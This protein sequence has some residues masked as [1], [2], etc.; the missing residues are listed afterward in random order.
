MRA[1]DRLNLTD[2]IGRELQS[3]YGYNE[4]DEFLGAFGI[5]PP[6]GITF[7]SKWV[8]SKAALAKVPES[9][10]LK[11]ASELELAFMGG[12]IG[13]PTPPKNWANTKLFRLFISHISKDKDKAIRL[14][15]CLAPLGII[16]FVA[17]EDIHPTLQ[18][19]GEIERAL[20]TMDAFIAVL[21]P[22][23]SAS[24][25]TQQEIGFALG[26]GVKIISFKMGEDPTGF[27]SREQAL[28]RQKRTAEEI[29]NEIG[30]LLA[31]DSRT[32]DRLLGARASM[33]PAG[34]LE[35]DVPF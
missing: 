13:D 4:I 19:Q 28:P 21:T 20:R 6:T 7:N 3:R 32:V 17:H 8:Y 11:I 10:L 2:Q 18:W 35:D 24:F 16:G 26:R 14:K 29:A 9:T 33:L 5:D 30:I 23:F 34:A 1:T 27:I 22:G 25:W 15:A 31:Q 12:L